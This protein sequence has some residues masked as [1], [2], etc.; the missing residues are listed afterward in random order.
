MD[1]LT[2]TKQQGVIILIS[3]VIFTMLIGVIINKVTNSKFKKE[4][5]IC[6]YY[7][8]D[9]NV[10]T[11]IDF[12]ADIKTPIIKLT[13]SYNYFPINIKECDIKNVK[14]IYKINYWIFEDLGTI[15]FQI[16]DKR[17]ETLNVYLNLKNRVK[18]NKIEIKEV[19]DLFIE[20]NK[21]G[22]IDEYLN[23]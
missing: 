20:L 11:S 5:T 12:I 9:S 14:D 15:Q 13:Y 2:L 10:R 8:K 16:V 22:T 21:Y 7:D 19:L 18:A 1:K 23:S 17:G 4:E 3:F 6:Y